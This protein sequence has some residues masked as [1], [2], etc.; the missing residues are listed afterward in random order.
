MIAAFFG[1][2]LVTAIFFFAVGFLAAGLGAGIG[3]VIPAWP[4]CCAIAGVAVSSARPLVAQSRSLVT[5]F[6]DAAP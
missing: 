4:A 6:S 3:I 2:G 5:S 1:A